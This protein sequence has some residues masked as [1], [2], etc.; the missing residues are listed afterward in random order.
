MATNVPCSCTQTWHPDRHQGSDLAKQKFQVRM[1]A[2]VSL[3]L[4]FD[5]R[6]AMQE[7]VTAFEVLSDEQQRQQYDLGL[8]EQLDVEE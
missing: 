6:L 8:L 1:G 5:P 7:I 2:R 4:L 3:G